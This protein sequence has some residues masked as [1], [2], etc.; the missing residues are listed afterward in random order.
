MNRAPLLS[1]LFFIIGI[2]S[3]IYNNQHTYFTHGRK[4]SALITISH[5]IDSFTFKVHRL[6]PS[7][8]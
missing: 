5:Q 4:S 2:Y 3:A 1:V 8:F 7:N 6:Q